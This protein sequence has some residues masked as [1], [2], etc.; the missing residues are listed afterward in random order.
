MI[1]PAQAGHM[2]QAAKRPGSFNV[3]QWSE[4]LVTFVTQADD[5]VSCVSV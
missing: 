4:L 2:D 1:E 3:G 5:V